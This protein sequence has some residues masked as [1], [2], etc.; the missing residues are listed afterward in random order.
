MRRKME[1]TFF[2]DTKKQCNGFKGPVKRERLQCLLK[3]KDEAIIDVVVGVMGKKFI[4][5]KYK[6]RVNMDIISIIITW[7]LEISERT[8]Q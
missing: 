5:M 7:G 8:L 3:Y 2:V 6:W 1:A 4:E